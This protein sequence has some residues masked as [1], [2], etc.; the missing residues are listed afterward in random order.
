[1]FRSPSIA[2]H[3]PDRERPTGTY[4]SSSN[5]KDLHKGSRHGKDHSRSRSH[6]NLHEQLSLDK[7]SH[8]HQEQ[9]SFSW[10][11]PPLQG[12]HQ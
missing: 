4:H 8:F 3:N 5:V 11:P 7:E 6:S 2:G 1:M 12:L 9:Y 10:S